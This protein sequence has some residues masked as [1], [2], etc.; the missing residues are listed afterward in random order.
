MNSIKK[1]HCLFAILVVLT[2]IPGCASN[3]HAYSKHSKIGEAKRHVME[4]QIMNRN[5]A[6]NPDPNPVDTTDGVYADNVLNVYRGLISDPG[7][8]VKRTPV[9][10][11]PRLSADN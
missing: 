4:A 5:V 7:I 2:V 10:A 1:G 11:D 3:R 6:L 9:T 8:G